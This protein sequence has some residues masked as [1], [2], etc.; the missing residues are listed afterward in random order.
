MSIERPFLLDC[1]RMVAQRW[2]GLMPTGIDRVCDAYRTHFASRAQAVV[3]LRGRARVLD[4]N[5]SDSLFAMLEGPH[6]AFRRRFAGLA[7]MIGTAGRARADAGGAIY[8]NVSHT[9][10]DLDRHLDWVQASGVRP[11]YLV[12][13]LIPIE[14][15]HFTTPHKTRRHA[16]RV[17][18]ALEAASGIIANSHTTARA[19]DAYARTRGLA[20]PPILGAPLGAPE[21]PLVQAETARNRRRATFVC[22]GTIERRKN[23][24]LLLDIWDRLIARDGEAAPRL[25]LIGRWGTGSEEVR[26]RYLADRRLQRFVQVIGDCSDAGIVRHLRSASALL[27]P[28]RA[29]GFGLP[30]VEALGLGVP[31]IASDIPAFREV[32]AG[33]PTFLDPAATAAWVAQI[34]EFSA[35]GPERQRQLAALDAYRAPDWR[36]HFRLV[37]DWLADLPFAGAEAGLLHAA[38]GT[39]AA[40]GACRPR[41]GAMQ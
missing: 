10:F 40:R 12:H 6:S 34:D 17:R 21:L 38:A 19:L 7:A 33:I 13:D 2:S 37:E 20:P 41:A 14:H 9:D 39:H 8:L 28:S 32:G 11:V 36:D 4:R 31:V 23:H 22:V 15:P 35:N 24:M 25:I 5:Q 26:R 29:E 30:V 3:Q 1:T 16:G 27:A 18:R